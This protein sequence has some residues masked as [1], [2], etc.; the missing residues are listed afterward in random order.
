MLF[1]KATAALAIAMSFSF[2]VLFQ[3]LLAANARSAVF[4]EQM[5]FIAI[6]EPDTAAMAVSLLLTAAMAVSLLLTAAMAVSLLLTAAMAALLC[7]SCPAVSIPAYSPCAACS[8]VSQSSAIQF[9]KLYDPVGAAF[10]R[11]YSNAS[12]LTFWSFAA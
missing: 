3:C 8:A 12:P 11:T 6:S 7:A 1:A 10:V 2:T 9:D 4:T 5:E